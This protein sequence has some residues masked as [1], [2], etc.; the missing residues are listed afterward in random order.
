MVLYD[1]YALY[2]FFFLEEVAR[3]EQVDRIAE[4]LSGSISLSLSLSF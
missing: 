3:K 4:V 1:V 2:F